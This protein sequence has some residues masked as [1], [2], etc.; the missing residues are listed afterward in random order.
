MPRPRRFPEDGK[1][2]MQKAQEYKS[3]LNL[4]QGTKP[5]CSSVSFAFESNSSLIDKANCVD[6]ML[7][8]D[9]SMINHNVAFMKEKEL[10]NRLDFL[11]KNPDINL[12]VSLDSVIH[13]ND[14]P[15]LSSKNI[16]SVQAPLKK[17]D[18]KSASSWVQIVSKGL[19]V[20][21]NSSFSYDRCNMEH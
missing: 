7:G 4:S 15:D 10:N 20:P 5:S 18:D 6:I 16:D 13:P 1:T 17:N 19:E 14:Y 8:S 2:M 21:N 12:P 3:Y 11:E 9:T